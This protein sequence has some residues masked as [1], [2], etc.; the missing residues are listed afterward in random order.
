MLKDQGKPDVNKWLVELTE[1]VT[2][3]GPI[4]A[5]GARSLAVAAV[6]M[7]FAALGLFLHM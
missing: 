5:A 4:S 6:T 1:P 7:L 2:K 3:Q